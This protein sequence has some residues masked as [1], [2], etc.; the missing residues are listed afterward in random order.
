MTVPDVFIQAHSAPLQIVF[1]KG[2]DFPAE[3]DGSAFV[4]LRGSWN[5]SIRTGY[6]VVRLLFDKSGKSTGE[7]EDFMTGLVVSDKQVWGRPRELQSQE[8]TRP[9]S[10]RMGTERFGAFLARD[11]L[12]TNFIHSEM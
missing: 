7:Y 4:T 5:R 8:T 9:L 3:Y 12:S 11:Q 2:E 1:Y 10:R 6:K